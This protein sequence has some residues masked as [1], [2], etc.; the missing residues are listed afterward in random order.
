[1]GKSGSE[2]SQKDNFESIDHLMTV[3]DHR[4]TGADRDPTYLFLLRVDS[5]T[6][7]DTVTSTMTFQPCELLSIIISDPIT[8]YPIPQ[9]ASECSEGLSL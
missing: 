7:F 6:E 3:P 2:I 4:L 8:Y 9:Q 1:M 5:H